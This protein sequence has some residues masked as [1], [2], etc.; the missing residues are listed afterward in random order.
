MSKKIAA[1]AASACVLSIAGLGLGGWAWY[2]AWL[3]QPLAEAV[4]AELVTTEDV[5]GVTPGAGDLVFELRSLDEG[6]N[7]ELSWHCGKTL[8]GVRSEYGGAW[9]HLRG[10]L[11]LER[12]TRTLRAGELMLSVG[13]MR[14]HGGHPAPAALINTLRDHGWFLTEQHPRAEFHGTGLRPRGPDETSSAPGA[15]EDWTHVL[16]GKLLLNGVERELAVH[17][18]LELG[19]DH[20][21]LDARFPISRSEFAIQRRTGIEPPA[22]VDDRVLVTVKVR[23][24]R[25]PQSVVAELH[26][27]LVAQE[28][29]TGALTERV[30]QLASGLERAE[31]TIDALRRELTKLAARPAPTAAP[32]AT[33]PARFSDRVDYRNATALPGF[34][35]LGYAP[36]FEMVLVPGDP[37][38]GI[39]PFYVQTTEVTWQMY[40]AWSYCEDVAEDSQIA[41]LRA[42]DLR[43]SP[44]YDDASRGF[45]FEGRAALGLS[46]RNAQAFCRFLSERTQRPYRLMTGAEWDHLARAGG[47]VPSDPRTVAW[48]R[49]NCDTDLFGEPMPMPVATKPANAL[50]LF[51]F[52]GNVAEWVQD[53]TQHVRGGSYLTGAKDLAPTWREDESQDIWNATYPNRPKSRWWYRDRF[54]MGFRLVCDPVN[55]PGEKG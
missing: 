48:L 45:G 41:A 23:A 31:Q 34:K 18:K 6:G 20:V 5:A 28:A 47:G 26:S 24:S 36:E 8:A 42:G 38:A 1:L 33:L 43:P 52:W 44:C 46:R 51:D 19:E 9:T 12:A 22:E 13:A 35:D 40:R 16:T 17:A 15:L 10:R 14:G 2:T 54:D 49:D 27:A 3:N 29:R 25:D 37:N 4:E 21:H 50:G 55:V 53:E 32:A 7:T 39:A 11:L 30:E